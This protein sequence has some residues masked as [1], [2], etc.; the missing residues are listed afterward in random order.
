[1]ATAPRALFVDRD[2]VINEVTA[3][4]GGSP[5]SP[6]S[7]DELDIV[8][9]AAAALRRAHDAGYVVVVVT[10]QPDIARGTTTARAVREIHELM[11]AALPIDAFYC[12]PHDTDDGCTCRKPGPGMLVDAAREHS[13]DLGHSWLIGDRWVDI[14]AARA[15]GVRAVLVERP[16]SWEPT[17][18]GSAPIG[19]APDARAAD[20]GSAIATVLAEAQNS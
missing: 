8:P 19:L 10:N 6:L 4:A 18:S 15:A 7:V 12:C 3:V 13:L 20:L 1:M 17:S 14:A 5:R 9:D 16:W 2:G 11:A